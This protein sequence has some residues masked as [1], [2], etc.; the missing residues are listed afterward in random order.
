MGKI[1][2]I[3]GVHLLLSP[4]PGKTKVFK[5]LTIVMAIML[6]CVFP[7]SCYYDQ[8]AE[9]DPVDMAVS[10][11]T[12]IQPIFNRNCIICHPV[13]NPSPDLTEGNSYQSLLNR[14][15]IKANNLG[16]STLYQ[17][18]LG[19]PSIMPPSGGLSESDI[20]L[21]RNWIERG[22]LDN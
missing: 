14:N 19:N 17:R 9:F 18:L 22:A 4:Y 8:N 12:D 13:I 1:K 5:G 6:L 11:K 20:N 16:A 7:L 2:K 15:L 3:A 21:F 10:F